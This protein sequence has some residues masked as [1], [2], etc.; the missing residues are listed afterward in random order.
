MRDTGRKAANKQGAYYKPVPNKKD[1]GG[2]NR[3][4]RAGA[5]PESAMRP[6][7][8]RIGSRHVQRPETETQDKNQ[9]AEQTQRHASGR[10]GLL[11]KDGRV[12]DLHQ[13]DEQQAP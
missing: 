2:R 5:W 10:E 8:K 3:L 9:Y 13:K 6:K 12:V 7:G 11:A 1:P 4:L